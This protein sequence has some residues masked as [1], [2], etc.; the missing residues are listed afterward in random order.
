MFSYRGDPSSSLIIIGNSLIKNFSVRECGLA[1]Q[2]VHMSGIFILFKN[3]LPN[4]Y[5]ACLLGA[6]IKNIIEEAEKILELRTGCTVLL[7]VLKK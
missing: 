4:S 1:Y 2:V 7:Q 3:F 5:S 6:R